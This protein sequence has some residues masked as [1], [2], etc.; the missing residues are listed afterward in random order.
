MVHLH[1]NSR[2]HGKNSSIL[3]HELRQLRDHEGDENRDEGSACEGKECWINQRLLHSIAQAFLLHQVFHQS[4]QDFRQRAA[5][6]ARRDQ[7]HIKG[8][9]NSREFT[10][11]LRKAAA[12]DQGLMQRANHLLY[13]R[14]L[15]TF[16]QNTKP[17]I[18]GHARLLQM[19]QL[20][21][22]DEQLAVRDP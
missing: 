16:L 3:R 6:L 15:E 11:G 4:H 7:V 20:F 1:Q 10:K 9:E 18:Q 19:R 5:G 14:M 22:E 12:L 17:F 8:R 13:A 21:G 2:P